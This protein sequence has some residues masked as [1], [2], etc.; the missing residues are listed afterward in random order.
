MTVVERSTDIDAPLEAVWDFY[1][2]VDGVVTLTPDW[3]N[4]RVEFV[5]GPEGDPNPAVLEAGSEVSLSIRPF[6]IGPRQSWTSRIVERKYGDGRAHFRDQMID[7]PV[8]RWDH[9]HRFSAIGSG[10]RITDRVEYTLERPMAPVTGFSRP[11]LELLFRYRHRRAR[12][13]LEARQS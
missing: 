12:T 7:G 1:S 2:T 11:V 10:T 9:T 6:G 4:L 8:R 5:S 13:V 3:L